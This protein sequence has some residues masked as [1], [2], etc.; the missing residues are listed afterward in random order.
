MSDDHLEELRGEVR[1][2]LPDLLRRVRAKQA[3]E[4][5]IEPV[6]PFPIAAQRAPDAPRTSSSFGE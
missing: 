1:A 2:W 3:G 6:G 5:L 4:V